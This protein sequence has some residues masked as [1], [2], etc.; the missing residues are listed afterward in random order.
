[1]STVTSA[2][3]VAR[4]SLQLTRADGSTVLFIPQPLY[5]EKEISEC[6]QLSMTIDFKLSRQSDE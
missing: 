6:I 5:F 2:K 1:M 4:V 3:S